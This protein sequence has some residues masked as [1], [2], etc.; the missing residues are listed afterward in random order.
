[1]SRTNIVT[2]H[3]LMSGMASTGEMLPSAGHWN[4][5]EISLHLRHSKKWEQIKHRRLPLV[6]V[7]NLTR[8]TVQL[9]LVVLAV[10]LPCRWQLTMQ[11]LAMEE[12][13]MNL[14]Q[15]KKLFFQME[16]NGNQNRNHTLPCSITRPI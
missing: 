3:R 12:S 2:G 14:L 1:M 16:R 9:E 15:V 5:R 4:G 8:F 7:L 13:I 6:W 10:L 11:C